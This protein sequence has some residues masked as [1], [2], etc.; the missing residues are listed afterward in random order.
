MSSKAVD[1]EEE[2]DVED[3]AE[4]KWEEIDDQDLAERLAEMAMTD[5]P[6][7]VDWIPPRLHGKKDKIYVGCEVTQRALVRSQNDSGKIY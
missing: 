3:Y 5:D 6:N 2:T 4:R 1:L 7:D